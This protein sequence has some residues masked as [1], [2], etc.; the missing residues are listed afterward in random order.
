MTKL[1]KMVYTAKAHATGGRGRRR[2]PRDLVLMQQF[3]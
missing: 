3:P 2:L 1:E